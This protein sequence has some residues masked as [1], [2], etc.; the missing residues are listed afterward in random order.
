MFDGMRMSIDRAIDET[1]AQLNTYG[2]RYDHWAI[3]WSGGKDST[4]LVTL[5]VRLMETGKVRRPRRLSVF[6]AD[7]RMELPPLWLAALEIQGELRRRGFDVH[8]VTA[9]IDERFWV[10][11]LGRGVPPP[12]ND[13]RWCT[14]QMKIEP[15]ESALAQMREAAGEKVLMLTGVR[16]GE[17]ASR[18]QTIAVS[19]SRDGAECGQGWLHL[20]PD[21]KN[22]DNINQYF[23]ASAAD[24]ITDTLAPILHFRTCLVWDWLA[25]T[26]GRDAFYRHGFPTKLLADAYDADLD[27]SVIEVSARTG[28][29]CCPLASRD[30]ALERI[31]RRPDWSYL[32]PLLELRGLWEAL[33]RPGMRLRKRG[34]ERRKDGTLSRNQNRKGPLTLDARRFAL[35]LVID[36]QRRVNAEARRLGRPAIDILN[37]EE[38]SRILSLIDAATWPDKW[39]GDEPLDDEPFEDWYEDGSRQLVLPT[40]HGGAIV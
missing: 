34:G 35:T 38:E 36:L 25:G 26:A 11:M 1:I 21:K 8:V 20:S 40:V 30:H 33:R 16:L 10:Y 18:D 19:C 9:P 17:S 22:F 29:I 37:D 2:E 28:C 39:A 5:L 6:Y 7:T 15:M 3:A 14:S 4:L 31:V 24:G 13:F 12:K 23:I 32:S 27:G